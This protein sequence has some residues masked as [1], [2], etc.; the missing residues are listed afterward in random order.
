VTVRTTVVVRLPLLALLG[1]D[2]RRVAAERSAE[3]VSE[4]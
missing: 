1:V 4:P 2:G 3:P